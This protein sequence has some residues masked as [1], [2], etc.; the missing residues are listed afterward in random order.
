MLVEEA[1][2]LMS[3]RLTRFSLRQHGTF[4]LLCVV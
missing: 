2:L 1:P 3:N 4:S